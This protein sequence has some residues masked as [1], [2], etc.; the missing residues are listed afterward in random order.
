MG[1]APGESPWPGEH[2]VA[3]A[4]RR[5]IVISDSIRGAPPRDGF[6]VIIFFKKIK[7]VLNTEP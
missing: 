4:V 2:A 6:V 5:G 1:L 7:F 3:R